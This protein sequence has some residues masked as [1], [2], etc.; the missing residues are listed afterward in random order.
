M[1]DIN[2]ERKLAEHAGSKAPPTTQQQLE[3]TCIPPLRFSF[4]LLRR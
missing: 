4:G 1:A 2:A 3:T